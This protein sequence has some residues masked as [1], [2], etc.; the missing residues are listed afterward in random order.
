MR[1]RVF[2]PMVS[3]NPPLDNLSTALESLHPTTETPV[4]ISLTPMIVA[5]APSLADPFEADSPDLRIDPN[6]PTSPFA[7]VGSVEIFVP[8]TGR[9]LCSGTAISPRHI[10]TAAHC[11]DIGEEDGIIDV[12][13]ENVTFN[14]NAQGKLAAPIAITAAE[15]AIF[16]NGRDRYEGF[17]SSI[18]DDLAII[19][20][21]QALPEGIPIYDLAQ[22]AL[23]P[24]SIITLVGYGTT[25]NGID[26]HIAG[27]ADER[28]KRTGQNQ[29][30]D[31]SLF[32]F[33][34]PAVDEVFMYDFDGPDVSTNSLTEVGSG[35]TLGNQIETTVGPGDSGGPSFI[36]VDDEWILVGVNTFGFAFPDLEASETEV[37]QG[38]FGTGGGGVVVSNPEK[39]DWIRSIVGDELGQDNL[40]L[41]RLSGTV[42]N[43]LNGD[44]EFTPVEPSLSGWTIYLDLNGNGVFDDDVE[45]STLTDE[46]GAYAFSD[47]VVDTYTVAAVIPEGWQQ[48]HPQA[49]TLDRFKADFSDGT[50]PDLDGFV[51]NNTTAGNVT[52]LWHITSAR[53]N[54]PGHSP[55]HSLYFGQNETVDGGGNYD[56]GHTAGQVTS[57]DINLVGLESADLIFNYF[58]DVEPGGV[59]DRLEVN[60][61]VNGQPFQ[62]IGTKENE[63]IIN[64][65]ET[66]QWSQASISLDEFVG[67]RIRVQFNFDTLDEF[68]NDLEGWFVDDVVVQGVSRDRYTIALEPGEDITGLNFGQQNAF[69]QPGNPAPTAP[70]AVPLVGLF[71]F[72]QHLRYQGEAAIPIPTDVIS[73]LPLVQLFDEDYYLRNNPDVGVAVSTGK[74]D[75]G[76]QHFVT[77][78]LFE[79]RDP[80]L[81]YSETF[82]LANHEDVAAAV[83]TGIHQSGLEHFLT[84]GHAENRNPGA[85]FDQSDYLTRNRDVAAAIEQGTLQSA[86]E[87]YIKYGA[88]EDNRLPSSAFP[89]VNSLFN[90]AFYLAVNPDVVEGVTQGTHIDGFD[91][92]IQYGQFENR[93]PNEHI[94][95]SN[96]LSANL[97]VQA[98]VDAGM[99]AS[100]F[101]HYT[102]YGRFENRAFG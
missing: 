50:A 17:S 5:G 89:V 14:V 47:L 31:A 83:A 48:T 27:T 30:D 19:T 46:T 55:E 67:N 100:G 75:S 6:V 84:Y 24:Q 90:E 77:F 72:E 51:I 34:I 39:L 45:P 85:R 20:L 44:G 11:L 37:I 15:L 58:L 13:P 26:G 73:D 61:S 52:G 1:F 81:L 33:V 87:H 94:S 22:E 4:D 80:S 41:G 96:Y 42:W 16:D 74:H 88:D 8:G 95:L 35:L 91:H 62:T 59:G 12:S 70:D 68:A 101:D 78:G 28:V 43:D 53:G 65:R 64:S 25:G 60:V 86:F 36:Q 66:Q 21:S 76:Y 98:A 3:P 9:F 82:Y 92:F 2:P 69:N 23:D 18:S 63:L 97:D 40:P 102:Q 99:Y 93:D 79:G 57:P 38:T 29:V 49:G 71:D 54:Q 7:G 32:S 10:L 56:V